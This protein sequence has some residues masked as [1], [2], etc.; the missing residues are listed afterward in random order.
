MIGI[1]DFLAITARLVV[2]KIRLSFAWVAAKTYHLMRMDIQ[3]L[4]NVLFM[5]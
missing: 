3:T 2:W 1:W 5:D 4:I